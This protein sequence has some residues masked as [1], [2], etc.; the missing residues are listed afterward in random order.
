[1]SAQPHRTAMN[2]T[3]IRTLVIS[4]AAPWL[5]YILLRPHVGAD[6]EALA[7]GGA[8]PAAWVLGRLAVTRKVDW[9]AVASVVILGAT[10][11]VSLALGGSSLPIK[12]RD[13]IITGGIGLAC[14]VSIMMNRPLLIALIH[15]RTHRNPEIASKVDRALNEPARHRRLTVATG[16]FGIT[17]LADAVARA[18]LAVALSTS[19]FLAVSGVASWVIIAIGVIPTLIYLRRGERRSRPLSQQG[20]AP[21]TR[22]RT[23]T[24]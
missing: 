2:L 23:T 15:M 4:A 10:V 12:L 18:I 14:I 24:R 13:S 1:M 9:V 22:A 16:L 7:I 8:V 6:W 5:I 17:F 11:V 21:Q 20:P 3:L 19:T